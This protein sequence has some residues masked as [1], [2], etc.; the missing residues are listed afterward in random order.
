MKNFSS[1]TILI[2]MMIIVFSPYNL[3][4]VLYLNNRT[5]NDSGFMNH[6]K[7]ILPGPENHDGMSVK[8]ADE[9]VPENFKLFQN[10][11]NPFNP[12]TTIK[13]SLSR[14][15]YVSLKVYNS[16]G[17]EITTLVDQKQEPGIYT[18]DFDGSEVSSGVYYVQMKAGKYVNVKKMIL[19]K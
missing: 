6:V 12:V 8:S 14:E 5:S 3:S 13:Y 17:N 7:L 10:Y 18:T 4:E 9:T 15:A 11:P 1:I 16:L 19:L 2:F